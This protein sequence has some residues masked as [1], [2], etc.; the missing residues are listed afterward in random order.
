MVAPDSSLDGTRPEPGWKPPK[1]VKDELL[2][3]RADGTALMIKPAYTSAEI[4]QAGFQFLLRPLKA[5]VWQLLMDIVQRRRDDKREAGKADDVLAMLFQLSFC[6]LGAG[7]SIDDLKKSQQVRRPPAPYR[8]SWL[9]PA[10]LPPYPARSPAPSLFCRASSRERAWVT[11]WR[12][13]GRS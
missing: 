13:G 9:I 3:A 11:S 5:Q 10:G 8:T 6:T 2:A 7:Y 12:G 1:E 4:S